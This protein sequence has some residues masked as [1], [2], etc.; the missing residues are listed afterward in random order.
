MWIKRVSVTPLNAIAKV[1]DSLNGSSTTNAPSIH[2]VNTALGSL[3][4]SVD[5]LETSVEALENMVSWSSSVSCVVDDTT[6]TI[7]DSKIA[8]TSI[9]EPFSENASGDTVVVTNITV[10][11][12]QAVLSFDALTEATSFKLRIT[13]L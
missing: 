7:T 9:I 6:C 10:T 2:A 8:T 13:N 1:I 5:S 3:E 11:T 4:D 12:G